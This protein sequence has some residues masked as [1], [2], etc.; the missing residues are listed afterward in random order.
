M[1]CNMERLKKRKIIKTPV[2][3]NESNQNSEENFIK[4]KKKYR[5]RPSR[6]QKWSDSDAWSLKWAPFIKKFKEFR[7]KLKMDKE[8]KNLENIQNQK[9]YDTIHNN[10]QTKVYNRSHETD[11]DFVKQTEIEAAALYGGMTASWLEKLK[12]TDNWKNLKN[13]IETETQEELNLKIK[14][15]KTIWAN[16]KSSSSSSPSFKQWLTSQY[17]Q[18]PIDLKEFSSPLD[19]FVTLSIIKGRTAWLPV[20]YRGLLKQFKVLKEKGVNGRIALKKL[21]LRRLKRFANIYVP[22]EDIETPIQ[23]TLKEFGQ[24]KKLPIGEDGLLFRDMVGTDEDKQKRYD[25][26]KGLYVKEKEEKTKRESAIEFEKIRAQ[27]FRQKLEFLNPMTTIYDWYT[28]NTLEMLKHT[29]WFTQRRIG[30][31]KVSGADLFLAL[32]YQKRYMCSYLKPYGITYDKVKYL[33]LKRFER[34]YPDSKLAL[35]DLKKPSIARMFWLFGRRV[36]DGLAMPFL[37]HRI[38]LELAVS[39]RRIKR[40]LFKKSPVPSQDKIIKRENGTCF[41]SCLEKEVQDIL[42]KIPKYAMTRKTP[43][44]NMELFFLTFLE[45]PG[46]FSEFA[47]KLLRTKTNYLELRYRLENVLLGDATTFQEEIPHDLQHFTF[48]LKTGITEGAFQILMKDPD[49]LLAIRAFRRRLINGIERINFSKF[50]E[51][52]IFS[53]PLVKMH[54]S[55]DLDHLDYQRREV[56]LKVLQESVSEIEQKK[57]IESQEEKLISLTDET[58]LLEKL[59]H[60]GLKVRNFVQRGT[61]YLYRQM[62]RLKGL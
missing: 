57:F 49:K 55:N 51:T 56:Y 24:N 37:P 52:Y 48:L 30:K 34:L 17:S 38:R 14:F 35:S 5:R 13:L 29:L 11:V 19:H 31:E 1:T 53:N 54:P 4:H 43:V 27:L 15:Q 60:M 39:Y 12:K 10:F 23:I 9:V 58:K 42:D 50:F 26:R 7:K 41:L 33:Y 3:N 8:L 40:K 6:T 25:Y 28:K 20:H 47:K 61:K 36:E 62:K 44:I 59:Q 21:Q 46:E 2:N 45:E 32:F 22:K 18:D 16:G